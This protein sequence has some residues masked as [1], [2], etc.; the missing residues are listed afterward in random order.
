[1]IGKCYLRK[2]LE[3]CDRINYT[4]ASATTA[5]KPIWSA[6]FGVLIPMKSADAAVENSYYRGGIFRFSIYTSITVS[7]GDLVYYNTTNDAVVVVNPGTSGFLLGQA[8]EDGTATAGYVDVRIFS[9]GKSFGQAGSPALPS[10]L[11]YNG[12]KSMALYTTCASSNT[13]TSYEPQYIENTMTN[14]DQVGG[15]FRVHLVRNVAGTA[16]WVNAFKASVDCGTLGSVNG[17]LSASCD[18]VA[19]PAKIVGTG[20]YCA[21]ELELTAAANCNMGSHPTSFIYGNISGDGT[22]VATVRGAGYLF[23]LDGLGTAST[24]HAI[25]HTTGA[26]S[27]THG[28]R[29]LIDGVEYDFL[30]K[31]VTYA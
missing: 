29:V 8:V 5:W 22:A 16:G 30:L 25:F 31:A 12:A 28:L 3:A 18:E 4:C 24:T 27:G 9:T 26:V 20:T 13:G 19:L 15:R 17:L 2:E 6:E 23:Q 11:I 21:K 7:A 14:G 10:V 1:M